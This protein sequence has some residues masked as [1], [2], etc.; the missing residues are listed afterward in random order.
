MLDRRESGDQPE[1]T[2]VERGDI[3][4]KMQRGGSDHEVLKRDGKA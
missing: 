1:M 4:A 3:E 2:R